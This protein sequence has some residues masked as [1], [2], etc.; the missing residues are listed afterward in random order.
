MNIV[1]NISTMDTGFKKSEHIIVRLFLIPLKQ[2]VKQPR[3]SPTMLSM[4][5]PGVV[6]ATETGTLQV[7]GI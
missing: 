1:P 7:G 3:K 5:F 4:W 2:L 6:G